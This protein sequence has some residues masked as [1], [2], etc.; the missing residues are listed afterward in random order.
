MTF[1]ELYILLLLLF[2]GR[3]YPIVKYLQEFFI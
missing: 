2:H 1:T 3:K